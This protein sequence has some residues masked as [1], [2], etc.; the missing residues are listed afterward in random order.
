MMM[1]QMMSTHVLATKM[2]QFLVEGVVVTN[3]GIQHEVI[4]L[5]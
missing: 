5:L 2:H 1:Q 4:S 3:L